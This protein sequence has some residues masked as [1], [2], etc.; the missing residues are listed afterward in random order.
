M[1]RSLSRAVVLVA[2]VG[3]AS[4]LPAWAQGG[5]GGG[6]SGGG[7]GGGGGDG[8][9]VAPAGRAASVEPALVSATGTATVSV[10][11]D[12]ATVTL[13]VDVQADK[14]E[15]AHAQANQRL[16]K[17]LAALR[18]V[19]LAQGEELVVQSSVISLQPVF[20]FEPAQPGVPQEP[21]LTGFRASSTVTVRTG[22]LAAVGRLI[23]AGV[24]AGA[25]RVDGIVFD[26]KDDSKARADALV[27][28]TRNAREQA[29]LMLDALGLPAGR[30]VSA[31]TG[32]REM[33]G[34]MPRF[35]AA[36]AMAESAP[37]V[38]EPGEISVS[39][40][41]TVTIEAGR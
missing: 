13:G 36:K 30:V 1:N 26:L 29:R 39:A 23:D 19:V 11:P 10:R 35:G 37:T 31:T 16:G 12:R 7:S 41:V 3:L 32:T 6:G 18:A 33:P 17:V 24:A 22:D 34:P 9:L 4:A 25:N 8:R 5:G 21:K 15:Q 27:R 28:A 2:L 14:S 40:E 38:V 20:S